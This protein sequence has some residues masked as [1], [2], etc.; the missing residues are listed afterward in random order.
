MMG[1]RDAGLP[2]GWAS[3]VSRLPEQRSDQPS[4]K[5]WLVFEVMDTGACPKS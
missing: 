3:V 1:H 2:S 4:A 5:H